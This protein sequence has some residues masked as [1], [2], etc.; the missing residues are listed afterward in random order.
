M[1]FIL[2][3]DPSAEKSISDTGYAWG[4]FSKD[5]PLEILDAGVIHGGFEGFVKQVHLCGEFQSHLLSADIVVCEKFV[6]WE[7]RADSTPRLLEGVVRFLRPDAV[8]QPASGKNSLVPDSF[9]KAQGLW[10][11]KGSHHNDDRESVRHLYFFLAKNKHIPTL[12]QLSE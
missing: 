10:K 4:Q 9:L 6:T 1:T 11:S 12:K 5:K 2:G 3:L 8:M 7:P